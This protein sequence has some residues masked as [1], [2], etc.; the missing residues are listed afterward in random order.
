MRACG[1][2]GFWTACRSRYRFMGDSTC[3][4][5]TAG[6]A[7]T[8]L[9]GKWRSRSIQVRSWTS[10][11]VNNNNVKRTI[12]S[13]YIILNTVTVIMSYNTVI[14][15]QC[16]LSNSDQLW[17]NSGHRGRACRWHQRQCL[18]S[19]LRRWRK[20]RSSGP[21]ESLQQF[22]T[23]HHWDLQGLYKASVM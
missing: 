7:K 6:S 21:Y 9:M 4:R 8:R 23:W 3:S 1:P 5:A 13:E 14:I 20:N 19:D 10:N 16:S 15:L 11:N 12:Q 2:D 18:L 17:S 22:W